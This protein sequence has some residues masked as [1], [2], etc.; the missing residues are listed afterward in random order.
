MTNV[1]RREFFEKSMFAAAALSLANTNRAFAA[2]GDAPPTGDKLRVA[3]V[4]VKGRGGSHIQGFGDR[5][6]CEIAALVDVD[7]TI[8][9]ARADEIEQRLLLAA[10]SLAFSDARI[11]RAGQFDCQSFR[12]P[13]ASR[14]LSRIAMNSDERMGHRHCF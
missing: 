6:D 3:V 1:S 14:S 10:R 9:N 13:S 8:I 12:V 4:G 11:F 7:E 2:D 5:A